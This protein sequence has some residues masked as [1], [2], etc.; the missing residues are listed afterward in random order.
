MAELARQ[1]KVATQ[2]GN[3]GT[4]SRRLRKAAALSRAGVVGKSK[5]VHVW[6]NRPVWPQGGPRPK[7]E[8]CRQALK[9]DLWIGP[10]PFRALT[11]TDI[12]RSPGAAGGI[13][14][15]APW[16]TWPATP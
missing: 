11:P 5:E 1:N 4:A 12:I 6:T 8:P 13:S 2:M 3:Q 7:E 10:A 16:A 9:W 14:A 15:A